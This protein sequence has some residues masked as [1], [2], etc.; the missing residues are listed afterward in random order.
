MDFRLKIKYFRESNLLTQEQLAEKSGLSQAY[1]SELEDIDR[2]KSPTLYTLAVL[3][4]ALDICPLKLLECHCKF[5][6]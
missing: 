4:N 3:A 6:K 1:I 2:D 5:C